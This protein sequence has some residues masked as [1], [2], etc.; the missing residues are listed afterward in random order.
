MKRMSRSFTYIFSLVILLIAIY[1]TTVKPGGD[2]AVKITAFV[3]YIVAALFA[4]VMGYYAFS[5][6][7]SKTPQGRITG[8][9]TMALGLTVVAGIFRLYYEGIL[10]VSSYPSLAD[11]IAVLAYLPSFIGLSYGW[12]RT[13]NL[14][15]PERTFGFLVSW[16]LLA[17]VTFV[18]LIGPLIN[19]PATAPIAKFLNAI[20]PS[21]DLILVLLA[22]ILTLALWGGAFTAPWGLIFMGFFALAFGNLTFSFLSWKGTYFTGHVSDLFWIGGFVL[23]A[24]GLHFQRRVIEERPGKKKKR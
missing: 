17:A 1:V 13:R 9:L 19:D 11:G 23:I 16:L 2:Y 3:L 21:F 10:G 15:Y 20:Y 8:W 4:T 6:Y 5:F 12:W 24:A 18:S 22:G 7:K 14:A